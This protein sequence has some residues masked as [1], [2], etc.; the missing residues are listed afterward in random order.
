[1][2][3][4]SND[5]NKAVAILNSEDVVAIPTE[6]VYGLAANIYSEKAIRKIFEVKQRPLFNPLIV[7]L[8][9]ITQL[10]NIVTDFPNKAKKLAEAFWPGS[11]TLVMKKNDA[12]PNLISAGK[13]TVAVRIPNHPV[14]LQLLKALDFPLAAPSANPFNR[15]SPTQALH[16]EQYF[17]NDIQ[18]VLEGGNCTSGIE[19]TIIGFE[20]EEA[21]L[22]RLGAISLEDIEAVIG[23]IK[24]KNKSEV[25]PAAPGMLAKHYSPTTKTFLVDDV[26]QFVANN[27]F[28][29]IG[30]LQFKDV[31]ENEYI[32]HLEVLSK[33]GNLNEA[34]A[35]LYHAMHTLD[36][37]NLEAIVIQK[38][39]NYGLGKSMNDRLER[40]AK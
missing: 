28:K 36:S 18:M 5:I 21:V 7:H 9:S 26:L 12:I 22:Y 16:V 19:S 1:M 39:P 13:D 30:V 40:A 2:S 17:K 15:I 33:T 32:Q 29:K 37:L 24:I 4:I 25:A 38:M 31:V 35:N 27:D 3:I 11:L 20:G 14:T 23:S 8:H 6:T 10:E 34:T